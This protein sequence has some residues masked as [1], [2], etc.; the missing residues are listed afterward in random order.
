M[1]FSR[2]ALTPGPSPASGRGESGWGRGFLQST[3]ST[4]QTLCPRHG[5]QRFCRGTGIPS[6][7][8]INKLNPV[9]ESWHTKPQR[10]CRGT[11]I[12]S[13]NHIN[14]LNPVPQT[15][16]TK[17]PRCKGHQG[18]RRGTGIVPTISIHVKP[19]CPYLECT[20]TNDTGNAT[21]L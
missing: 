20:R 7:N 13:T 9:P 12:P 3:R 21:V 19:P 1:G 17:P 14:K 8:H 18:F 11:G 10:F 4:S 15:W 6:T 2:S 16:H 5:T